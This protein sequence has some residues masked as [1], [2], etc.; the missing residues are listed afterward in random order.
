MILACELLRPR[1]IFH[2]NA[3]DR[4]TSVLVTSLHH[5]DLKRVVLKVVSLACRALFL[6]YGMRYGRT[7]RIT[8][9]TNAIQKAK[10]PCVLF[11][12]FLDSTH[13]IHCLRHRV[14]LLLLTIHRVLSVILQGGCPPV[15]PRSIMKIL[16]GRTGIMYRIM[17]VIFRVQNKIM[18]AWYSAIL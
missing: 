18:L 3:V 14:M 17:K 12:S 8:S 7:L 10:Y 4:G 6:D 1:T 16:R 13:G 9:H 5:R 11:Y 15:P 2:M